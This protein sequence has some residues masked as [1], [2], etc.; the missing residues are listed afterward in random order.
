[1]SDETNARDLAPSVYI[2][3]L[4][5]HTMIVRMRDH[6]E[7]LSS[8]FEPI[9]GTEF[10]VAIKPSALAWCLSSLASDLDEA[11]EAVRWSREVCER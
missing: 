1:M 7:M 5:A 3:L 6:V 2:N 11:A 4:A 10:E 8:V 9:G